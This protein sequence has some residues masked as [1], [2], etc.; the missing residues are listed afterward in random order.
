MVIFS[1]SSFFP[2]GGAEKIPPSFLYRLRRFFFPPLFFAF[3]DFFLFT[4]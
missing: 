4:A 3:S 1:I 2:F